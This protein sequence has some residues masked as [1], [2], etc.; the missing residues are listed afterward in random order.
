MVHQ[1]N[2][3]GVFARTNCLGFKLNWVATDGYG[4]LNIKM[5]NDGRCYID[6]E[7]MS[8]EFV[9]EVLKK[10]VDDAILAE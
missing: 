3:A 4:E 1:V 6:S 10:L 5:E 2:L 8:K 9:V 7:H